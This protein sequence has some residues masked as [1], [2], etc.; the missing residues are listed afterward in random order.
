MISIWESLSWLFGNRFICVHFRSMWN[1]LTFSVS[2][3]IYCNFWKRLPK[4]TCQKTQL[5][6]L[7]F[8]TFV[9]A[10]LC[11]RKQQVPTMLGL[12]VHR[13]KDTTHK[14]LE[15]MCNV[16]E[17]PQQC[18]KSCTND[19]KLLRATLRRSQKKR[20]VRSCL[21]KSLTAFKLCSTNPNNTQQRV[22]T[23]VTCNIQKCFARSQEA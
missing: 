18:W 3:K 8:V 7:G 22:Q 20:K 1:P 15:T 13:G 12:A 5:T 2:M 10:V 19:P 4:A 17:R 23:D 14:T 21:L 16:R 6:M 11:K 9:L